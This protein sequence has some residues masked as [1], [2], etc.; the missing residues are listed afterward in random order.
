M[1]LDELEYE[2]PV[3]LEDLLTHMARLGT[4]ARILAGG[5]DLVPAMR[6]GKVG[7]GVTTLV[8][9]KNLPLRYIRED[10]D[11]SLRIGSATTHDEIASSPLVNR[12]APLLAQGSSLVGSQQIRNVATIGGNLCNAGPSADT[13]APLLALKAE[14]K[15]VSLRG[16]RLVP[17]EQFYRGPSVSCLE[18]EEVLTEVIIPRLPERTGSWYEKFSPRSYMDLAWVG[19][20]VLVQLDDRLENF[21]QV[22]IGLSAVNPIPMR[23]KKAEATLMA[24]PV[25]QEGIE[26]AAEVASQEC[27][28]NPRSRRVPA[29]YRREIVRVL[30][31]RLI[32]RAVQMAR[33]G[34]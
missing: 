1:S 17:V 4:K 15:V 30:T 26:A 21:Q 14:L 13:A 12:K 25:C 29:A 6:K 27:N 23:A 10:G 18:P 2:A 28:P 32:E 9:L 31:R 11:G 34:R 3:R 8:S 24:A 7:S 19:V 16:A 5:T 20:A 22:R 33:E